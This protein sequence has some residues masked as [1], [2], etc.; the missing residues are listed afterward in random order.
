MN[1]HDKLALLTRPLT[2]SDGPKVFRYL[3]SFPEGRAVLNQHR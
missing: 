1:A 3:A 2:M